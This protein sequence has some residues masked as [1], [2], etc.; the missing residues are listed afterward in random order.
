MSGRWHGFAVECRYIDGRVILADQIVTA[1]GEG[2]LEGRAEG[3][4][5]GREEGLVKGREEGL[6]KGREEGLVKGRAEEK[7]LIAR[8]LRS[9]G[10]SDADIVKCT[11]LTEEELGSLL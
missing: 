4:E 7:V 6:V 2:K 11:G 3:Y 1:R 8:N 5:E 10:L 9:L